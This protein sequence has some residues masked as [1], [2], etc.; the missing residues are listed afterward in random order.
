MGEPIEVGSNVPNNFNSS[1]F[2]KTSSQDLKGFSEDQVKSAISQEVA[3]IEDLLAE[4]ES[5]ERSN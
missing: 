1:N 2:I 3:Q 4:L 5:L